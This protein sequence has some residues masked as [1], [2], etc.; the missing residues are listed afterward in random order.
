MNQEKIHSDLTF[1]CDALT[2]LALLGTLDLGFKH[3]LHT[4]LSATLVRAFREQ[5]CQKIV[6]S[7]L[8][9]AEELAA[10]FDAE[11][12]DISRHEA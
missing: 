9:S 2:A 7:E 8:L 5:L 6:E 3:L 12:I 1:T 10:A 11:E 4:G